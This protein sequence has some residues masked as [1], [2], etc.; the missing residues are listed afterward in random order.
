MT[1]RTVVVAHREAMFAEGIAAALA[2]YPGIAPVAVAT[3][4]EE[5]VRQGERADA[6]ALDQ[7]LPGADAAAGRLR[8]KGVRVVFLG[9]GGGEDDGVRV[10]TRASVEAL[11]RALVPESAAG[12][13]G[14]ASLSP[15][16]WEILSLVAQGLAGKQVARILGISPKTVEQHKARIFA[17]LG[18]PNQ[19]AA[20]RLALAGGVGRSNGWTLSRI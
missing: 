18:V 5:G 17:K 8:R 6:V 3:T 7:D 9:P 15:R 19:T 20:V 10:S 14:S 13:Q 4:A 1:V 11:A 16:Q 12:R 2:G